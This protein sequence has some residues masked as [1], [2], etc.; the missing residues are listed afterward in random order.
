[1]KQRTARI[2]RMS[3]QMEQRTVQMGRKP[4][5]KSACAKCLAW[6]V[7]LETRMD[8][9]RSGHSP[10]SK[11]LRVAVNLLKSRAL[12]RLASSRCLTGIKSASQWERNSLLR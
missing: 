9:C 8:W 10:G 2:R 11:Y 6:L 5:Q 12:G 7:V 1:M 4:V 3:F